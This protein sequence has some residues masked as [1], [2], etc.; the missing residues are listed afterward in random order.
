[1]QRPAKSRVLTVGDEYL[2]FVG[3]FNDQLEFELSEYVRITAE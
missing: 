1:M 2:I 3:A